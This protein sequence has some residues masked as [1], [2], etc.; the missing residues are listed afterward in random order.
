MSK[1]SIK[2]VYLA[3]PFS[4]KEVLQPSI[5]QYIAVYEKEKYFA[6]CDTNTKY[7]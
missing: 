6:V 7:R 1:S 3:V 2:A 4:K 5:V